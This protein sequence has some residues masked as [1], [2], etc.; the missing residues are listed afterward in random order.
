MHAMHES[1]QLDMSDGSAWVRVRV[2][3]AHRLW[4]LFANDEVACWQDDKDKEGRRQRE[5]CVDQHAAEAGVVCIEASH[6]MGDG[7]SCQYLQM[8]WQI[9]RTKTVPSYSGGHPCQSGSDPAA[10]VQR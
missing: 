6:V 10:G 5:R 2:A 9:W 1:Q 8:T 4:G 7:H 3:F